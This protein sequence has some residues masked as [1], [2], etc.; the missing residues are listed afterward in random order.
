MPCAQKTAHLEKMV[1]KSRGRVGGES[2]E[3]RGRV[4]EESG[5][6]RGESGGESGAGYLTLMCKRKPRQESRARVGRVG[7]SVGG[8][9]GTVGQSRGRAVAN[10]GRGGCTH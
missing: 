6:S 8:E 7:G 10:R 3:S 1:G 9:S 2:G 4:R 5:K